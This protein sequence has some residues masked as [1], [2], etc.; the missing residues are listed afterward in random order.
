MPLSGPSNLTVNAT[1]GFRV[2]LSHHDNSLADI[3]AC[4]LA[5]YE[6]IYTVSV[7]SDKVIGFVTTAWM[8]HIGWTIAQAASSIRREK[9]LC[10]EWEMINGT[11]MTF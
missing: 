1:R 4:R 11:D 9:N 2:L 8:V 5:A 6:Y 7:R 3:K 10:L